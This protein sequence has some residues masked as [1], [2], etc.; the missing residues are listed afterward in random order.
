[1]DCCGIKTWCILYRNIRKIVIPNRTLLST[2]GIYILLNAL[3]AALLHKYT[4]RGGPSPRSPSLSW[5]SWEG[6]PPGLTKTPRPRKRQRSPGGGGSPPGKG[7]TI[8]TTLTLENLDQ[9]HVKPHSLNLVQNEPPLVALSMPNAS[10]PR[11]PGHATAFPNL[12]LVQNEP[13]WSHFR[14]PRP[15]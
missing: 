7:P 14:S 3:V 15:L 4:T 2:P 12:I 10:W 9:V 5:R 1:M 6:P 13:P 11:P 8:A